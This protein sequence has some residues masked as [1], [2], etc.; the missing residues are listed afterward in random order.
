MN[1][2]VTRPDPIAREPRLRPR[3]RRIA[4]AIALLTLLPVVPVLA[5]A[6]QTANVHRSLAPLEKPVIV[7]RGGEGELAG[8]R[9]RVRGRT[10]GPGLGDGVAALRIVLLA[11]PAD[12]AAARSIGAYG[13]LY[14]L[15]DGQGH[16]WN[17]TALAAPAKPGAPVQVTV[18]AT[19]PR[20]AADAVALE[21][22]PPRSQARKGALPSL[23]FPP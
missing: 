17:G 5:W 14:R 7:S 22:L 3:D 9:W 21:I 11:R 4:E 18:Q 6:D 1:L 20:A 13:T 8:V 19:L 16:V 12:A 10:T 2:D 15:R 23:R